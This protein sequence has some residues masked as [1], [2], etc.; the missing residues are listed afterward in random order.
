LELEAPTLD[1][2]RKSMPRVLCKFGPDIECGAIPPLLSGPACHTV[3]CDVL[4]L[5]SVT[6][7]KMVYAPPEYSAVGVPTTLNLRLPG[8]KLGDVSAR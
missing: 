7:A 5:G 1:P 4:F 8:V 3:F 6:V 2:E